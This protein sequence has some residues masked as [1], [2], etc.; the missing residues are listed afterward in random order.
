MNT[1]NH[2]KV[3]KALYLKFTVDKFFYS[4]V[5]DKEVKDGDIF[6]NL[7]NSAVPIHID[8]T[9]QGNYECVCEYGTEIH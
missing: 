2:G 4:K 5:N 6:N 3:G 8:N 7:P 1:D 9:T